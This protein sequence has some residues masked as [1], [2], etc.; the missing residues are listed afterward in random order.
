[1]KNASIWYFV[2][3]MFLIYGAIIFIY[4]M[5]FWANQAAPSKALDNLHPSVWWGLLMLAFGGVVFYLN[6][7]KK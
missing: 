5:Y 2:A 3:L 4:G 7:K 6:F 1:M